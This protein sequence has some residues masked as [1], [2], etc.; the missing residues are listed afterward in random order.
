MSNKGVLMPGR[1]GP[2]VEFL[3]RAI[4]CAIDGEASVRL[5]HSVECRKEAQ[6]RV[7]SQ[8]LYRVRLAVNL[9]LDRGDSLIRYVGVYCRPSL[10]RIPLQSLHLASIRSPLSRQIQ[11]DHSYPSKTSKTQSQIGEKIAHREK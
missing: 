3:T 1:E 8:V 5:M 10:P 7:R 6:V 4:E 2:G 9:H 11:T